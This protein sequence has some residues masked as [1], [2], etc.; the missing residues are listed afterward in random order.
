MGGGGLLGTA[1]EYVMNCAS[2]GP[3]SGELHLS[4]LAS[5]CIP[6]NIRKAWYSLHTNDPHC[7]HGTVNMWHVPVNHPNVTVLHPVVPL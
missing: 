1:L 4:Y 5:V 2:T 3:K 6:S 7:V